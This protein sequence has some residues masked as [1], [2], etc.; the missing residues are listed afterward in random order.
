[1]PRVNSGA[2]SG[3]GDVVARMDEAALRSL[4]LEA[5]V[6]ARHVAG[7]SGSA[8]DV[9]LDAVRAALVAARP[10]IE[11]ANRRDK[12]AAA[13]AKL[14]APLLKR[15]D[16]EGGKFDGMLQKLDE[17]RGLADPL[18]RVS[19][20]S[21]LDTGLRLYRCAC[22]I[23]VICVIF[24]SRPEAAVQIAA[25]SLKSANALILKG[26]REAAHTNRALTEAMRA[27][28]AAARVPAA[29]LQLVESRAEVSVL[30]GLHDCIDLIIPRGSNAL[31]SSIMSSTRI[32]V[33]GHADGICAVYLDASASAQIALPVVVDSKTD[34]P[35]AC[36]TAETLLVHESLLSTLWPL[37][38]NALM[39]CGVQLRCDARCLA[40]AKA[41][42]LCRPHTEGC[43]P[44]P[45]LVVPATDDDFRTEFGALIL[46]VRARAPPPPPHRTRSRRRARMPLR[47]PSHECAT[48]GVARC[49]AD[50]DKPFET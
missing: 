45:S 9:G 25:L 6:A 49:G 1:M 39:E 21:E 42:P 50:D 33:M 3:G 34:Y 48:Q 15:L 22:P 35:V 46:A 2:V 41:A 44:L 24:E 17:V 18:D 40:A 8:R 43:A 30:L 16:L 12:A 20:A 19:Y 11:E 36:N 47:L 14:G 38:A 27:G 23:G 26:G 29:A 13:T 32:P 28:L 37:V 31:V 5:R 10:A 7:L 4:A